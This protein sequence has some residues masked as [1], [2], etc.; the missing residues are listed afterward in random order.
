[1]VFD[2]PK[3]PSFWRIALGCQ[4]RIQWHYGEK[5]WKN[6]WVQERDPLFVKS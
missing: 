3:M 6:V 1:M 2:H 5:N 4:V